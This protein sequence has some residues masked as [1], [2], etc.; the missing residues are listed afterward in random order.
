MVTQFQSHHYKQGLYNKSEVY[1]MMLP[2]LKQINSYDLMYFKPSAFSY[3][4]IFSFS[5]VIKKKQLNEKLV[6]NVCG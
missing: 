1:N 6:L 2:L 5:K 3:I 4:G